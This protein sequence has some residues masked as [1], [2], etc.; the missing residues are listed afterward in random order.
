VGGGRYDG[1]IEQLGGPSMPGIG[2]GMGLE[3]VIGNLKKESIFPEK[4]NTQ[5]TLIAHLGKS[6][7]TEAIKLASQIRK[8]GGGA[9]VGP[10]RGLKSQLRYASSL[11]ASH[12]VIIGENELEKGEYTVRNLNNSEQHQSTPQAILK[13]FSG[14]F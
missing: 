13:K 4:M 10:S 5:M 1:L 7:K 11:N 9:V 8:R 6:A 2:F 3:R 12:A 14:D